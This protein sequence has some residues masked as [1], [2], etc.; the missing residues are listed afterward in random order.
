MMI[1]SNKRENIL[2]SF[3]FSRRESIIVLTFSLIIIG[4]SILKYANDNDFFLEPTKDVS[5][6]NGQ[7]IAYRID[8]NEANWHELRLLPGIGEAK[9]KSIIE[10]R[11]K[12]GYIQS[13]E[14][15]SNVHGIGVQILNALKD[16]IVIKKG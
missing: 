2:K 11:N 13:V 5:Q 6:I 9:A 7:N 10:Y 3:R 14:E 15:L 16:M 1:N 12:R 4:S 8:I